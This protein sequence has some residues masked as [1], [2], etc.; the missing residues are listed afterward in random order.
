MVRSIVAKVTTS[1]APPASPMI[2]RMTSILGASA[3]P[4]VH[5][6]AGH[7]RGRSPSSVEVGEDG[8]DPAVVVVGGLQVELEEDVGGV[9]G[10]GAFGDDEAVGD[11]GV[12]AALGHE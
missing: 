12:G 9:L 5:R 1:S 11:G 6:P 3:R 10:D 7:R 2:N 4:A 8:A